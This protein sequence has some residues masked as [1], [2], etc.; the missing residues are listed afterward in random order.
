MVVSAIV[1]SSS[2][3]AGCGKEAPSTVTAV[4]G[5]PVKVTMDERRF[6]IS[7]LNVKTGQTVTFEFANHGAVGHEAFIGT[8]AEQRQHGEDREA[9]AD[10]ARTVEVGK[11]SV[12]RLTYTFDTPGDLIVGCHVAGHYQDGMKFVVHV[13]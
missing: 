11:D 6:S 4:D 3:I 12:G 5:Q 1:F 9:A 8:E 7:R 2:F 13:A 10:R